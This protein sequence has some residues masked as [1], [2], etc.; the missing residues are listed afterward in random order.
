MMYPDPVRC[1]N[2]TLKQLREMA[3][4]A[5][6]AFKKANG[7]KRVY[8]FG[9]TQKVLALDNTSSYNISGM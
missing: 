9:I 1:R 2:S 8:K 5:T 7:G 3:K 4:I 6:K